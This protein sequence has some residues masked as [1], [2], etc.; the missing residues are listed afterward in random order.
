[1]VF[2]CKGGTQTVYG[3]SGTVKPGDSELK[4][5]PPYKPTEVPRT[6]DTWEGYAE[7]REK[8]FSFIEENKIEGVILI[9]ADRHRSDAW[10]ITRENG[11]D[12]YE[13]ES[14]KLTNV[15]THPVFSESIFGYNEKCSF[16]FLQ[17]NT[18]K[19]DP[20]LTYKVVSI[21]NEVVN[22]LTIRR[23]Q[24]EFDQ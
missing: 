15:H 6:S 5:F 13:F 20:E 18:V 23:S 8:I 7:E 24:L 17:F 14:S 2:W 22:Q 11:Y 12:F 3:P 21:D 9:S 19:R 10:K 4:K 16:G 1:M